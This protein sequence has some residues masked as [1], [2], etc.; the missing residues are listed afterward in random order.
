MTQFGSSALMFPVYGFATLTSSHHACVC[1]TPRHKRAA[2]GY[3]RRIGFQITES[4]TGKFALAELATASYIGSAVYIRG[5]H[6]LAIP[7][8][9]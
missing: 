1:A 2:R 4:V 5:N 8:S 9:S 6:I 7:T 3:E